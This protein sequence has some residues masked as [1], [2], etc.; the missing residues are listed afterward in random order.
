MKKTF[1]KLT[2]L[3]GLFLLPFTAFAE[4]PIQSLNKMSQAMRDLNYE[5]AF[6]QT[7]PTNMDSFRYRHIKQGQKVYAQLVT[8]DGEQQE[9]IQRGNLVS[10]FQ[11]DS[12]AFTINS[13]EIV[14]AL[15]AVIRTDF[16]K[17]SQNYDFIKLGKDRIAGRFVDTIRIVPKDDFR[18]QYLVFL[19]EENGLLLRSDMLDRE[20]KLLDQFRVVNLYIGDGLSVLVEYLTHVNVPPLLLDKKANKTSSFSWQP[21]W[22][23]KGF[24][25]VN[26]SIETDSGENISVPNNLLLQKAI[27][28]IK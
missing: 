18:Y 1:L 25:L 26:R 28:I 13:G 20:G 12:R 23:P 10:Y 19:D 16:S 5:I 24:K 3:L 7:T 21:G 17:L 4:E 11:P 22:L 14:D 15:P 2:A 8:L 27:E 6:V 9:I